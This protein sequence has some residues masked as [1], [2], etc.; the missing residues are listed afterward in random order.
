MLVVLAVALELAAGTGL[1]FV[2]GFGRVRETLGQIDWTWVPALAGSLGLSFIGY[3]YAYRGIFTVEGG[4]E[5]TKAQRWAVAAAGF[6]GFLA[7]GGGNLDQFALE[8]A[9]L[10]KGEAR[11]RVFALGGLELGVLAIGGCGTAIAVLAAGAPIPAD[12]TVPWAVLPVPGFLLA[13]WA[14]ERYRHRFPDRLGWRGL[15]GIFLECVHLIWVLF[16]HPLRWGWGWL[17]M[18]LFWTM[19]AFA[20]WAGMAAFGYQM[21]GAALFVG[22]ATGTIFTRRTGPLAGAGVLTLI[23][24]LT[25]WYCGAPLAVALA[26]VFAYRVLAF[27]LPMPASLAALPT[28]RAMKAAHQKARDENR[29]LDLV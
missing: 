28:L 8:A 2:A 23:L 4:P 15:P 21:N 14:A 29:L 1:A 19:D 27:W 16:A 22:F 11:V 3:Y 9:G 18:A 24:P 5:L 20:V 12:F 26:G 7:H 13:F 10:A 17:G 25:I 6:G